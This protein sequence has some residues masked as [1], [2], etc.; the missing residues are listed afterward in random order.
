VSSLLVLLNGRPTALLAGA[1]AF[2]GLL[3]F[4][5]WFIPFFVDRLDVG[6][7]RIAARLA[8]VEVELDA[9]RE[10]GLVMFHVVAKIEPGNVALLKAAKLLRTTVPAVSLD[11]DQ[12][13]AGLH[14]I[15]G[16][17]E[18]ANVAAA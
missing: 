13:I 18:G 4:L 14:S 1:I 12:I 3:R 10:F 15:P 7:G 8:H 17:E 5:R 9:W 2:V 11:L 6:H 16:T